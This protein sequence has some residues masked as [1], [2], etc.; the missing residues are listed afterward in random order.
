MRNATNS[1][2]IS[3]KLLTAIG[4]MIVAPV[5]IIMGALTIMMLATPVV[6]AAVVIAFAMVVLM[7]GTAVTRQTPARIIATKEATMCETVDLFP[8]MK[9]ETERSETEKSKT[10]EMVGV[11]AAGPREEVASSITKV[12]G[13]CPLGWMPGNTWR[14]GPDGTLSRPMCRPGA[15]ALS[16]LFRM[17]EGGTMERSTCCECIYAG[18]EVTF[19]IRE[20]TKNLREESAEEMVGALAE[21]ML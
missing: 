17:S 7:V 2:N 12:T 19:T 18:R 4:M 3:E 5:L 20:P 1:P 15:T 9:L 13:P 10:I 14:I 16:A 8:S 6:M 11:L 21:E